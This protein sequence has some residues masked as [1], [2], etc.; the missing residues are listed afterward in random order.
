M[1]QSKYELLDTLSAITLSSEA[2]VSFGEVGESPRNVHPTRDSAVPSLSHSIVGR[3]IANQFYH[4][5]IAD[6]QQY[7]L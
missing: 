1:Q 6:E 2:L 3:W 4:N 7:V 5:C